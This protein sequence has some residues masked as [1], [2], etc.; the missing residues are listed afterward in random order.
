MDTTVAN[1]EIAEGMPTMCTDAT[2]FS[3]RGF[4]LLSQGASFDALAT[5]DNLWLSLKI[6]SSGGENALHAHIVEDHAFVVINGRATFHLEGGKT[7]EVEQYE[8]VM[9]PKGTLYSFEAGEEEN[10]VLLRIGAAQRKHL[11]DTRLQKHGSPLEMKGLTYDEDGSVKDGRDPKTG[12]PSLEIIPVPG[13]FF[14]QDC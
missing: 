8:G 2:K 6:Y 11:E 12:T 1:P 9:L 10:L 5:A 3:M 13:K 7:M 4:P 14:P